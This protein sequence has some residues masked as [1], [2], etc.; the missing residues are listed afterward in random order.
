[1]ATTGILTAFPAIR[2]ARMPPMATFRRSERRRWERLDA[3]LATVR[4]AI[5]LPIG[6]RK[7]YL[8]LRKLALNVTRDRQV[9]ILIS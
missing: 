7:R 6:S 5:M 2:L 3:N 8:N 9:L 4:G 1:M